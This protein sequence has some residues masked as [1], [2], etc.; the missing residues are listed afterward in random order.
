MGPYQRLGEAHMAIPD[1]CTSHGHTR[2]GPN[3]ELYGHW[4][5]AGNTDPS[6]IRTDVFYLL[7]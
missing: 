5:E 2:A 6:Q 7:A 4:K 1:W 3:W